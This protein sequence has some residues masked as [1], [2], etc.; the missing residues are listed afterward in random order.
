L[1]PKRCRQSGLFSTLS[2]V[3]AS[4]RDERSYTAVRRHPRPRDSNVALA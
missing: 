1:P 3:D 2:R 4:A